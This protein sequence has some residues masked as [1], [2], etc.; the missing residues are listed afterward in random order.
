MNLIAIG[1]NHKTAPIDVREKFFLTST[2]QDLLLSE[3]KCNPAILEAFALSTCNRTEIYVSALGQQNYSPY[4]IRLLANIKKMKF[5][6][7]MS[8]HFYS[9]RD[10][11]AVA[12]LARVV[13]GLDS[14]VLG[15]KQIL[16]QVKEAIERAR[17]KTM[18]SKGFNILTNMIIRTGKKAQSETD[19]SY[20]GSS[21]SWAAIEMAEK[22]L[23]TLADT[24]VLI[25]GAG[26]MGELALQNIHNKGLKNIFVMNR[27]ETIAENLAKQYRG[28]PVSFYDIKEILSQVEVCICSVGA[29]HYILDKILVEKVMGLRNQRRL[30]L[31]DISMPRNIDPQVAGIENVYLSHLD[32]LDKVVGETMRKRLESVS[33]VE[34]IIEEKLKTFYKKLEKI[35][36]IPI[37]V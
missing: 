5:D 11:E 36:H 3:L 14:L 23:G 10:Q 34:A 8:K 27:T 25:I 37:S 19:I 12:H 29:P 6:Q 18:L 26:K 35:D 17:S 24:S 30:V 31:I 15:E 32:D 33:C 7:Q 20:G 13:T 4:F 2:E 1:I 16:G 9:Y 28:T 22:V 21:I